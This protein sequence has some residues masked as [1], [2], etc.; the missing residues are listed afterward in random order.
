ME[1][2]KHDRLEHRRNGAEYLLS[3]NE[4]DHEYNLRMAGA[5]CL[6]RSNDYVLR[7]SD[8]YNRLCHPNVAIHV[9]YYAIAGGLVL[10]C[11]RNFVRAAMAG[12]GEHRLDDG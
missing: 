10:E 5:G 8:V 9:L 6:F 1:S 12:A 2:A 11:T 4:P 3:P 7:F